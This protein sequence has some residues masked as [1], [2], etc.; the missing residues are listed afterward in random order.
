MFSGCEFVI[1][2]FQICFMTPQSALNGSFVWI[3]PPWA[4]HC[5]KYIDARTN[6][7]RE[8]EVISNAP[9]FHFSAQVI[10]TL[11]PQYIKCQPS[12][13]SS[14]PLGLLGPKLAISQLILLEYSGHAK[15]PRRAF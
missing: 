3:W 8:I 11:N 15:I 7:F 9:T 10:D 2:T 13:Q 6:L 14:W 1:V 4:W 5:L 12:Y